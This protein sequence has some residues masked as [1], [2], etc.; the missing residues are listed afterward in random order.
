VLLIRYDAMRRAI[1][2]AAAVDEVKDIRDNAVA[3]QLYARQAQDRELE[4][5]CREIRLRAERRVGELLRERE[6][7]KGT[8]GQLAG[9]DAS[10]DA[11]TAPPEDVTQ[12]LADLGITKR[13]SSQWQ[14]LADV[15]PAE[16]EIHI[17]SGATLAEIVKAS[18]Q[19]APLA[20]DVD[21]HRLYA[22]LGG[23]DGQP[24][25]LL[26]FDPSEFVGRAMTPFVRAEITRI[27]PLAA[28]WLSV[29]SEALKRAR[30]S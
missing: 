30:A 28:A 6:M 4:E 27:A 18:K 19:P 23:L 12:T 25:R 9:R 17:E 20:N 22:L 15:P 14:R 21:A 29:L 11:V 26:D 5:R 3:L 1:A 8:R 13:Q 2:A 10:G 24:V 7:A 16:F